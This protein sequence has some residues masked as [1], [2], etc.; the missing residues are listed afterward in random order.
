MM[1]TVVSLLAHGLFYVSEDFADFYNRTVAAFFRGLLSVVT[2]IFPFSL[3]EL[4]IILLLP[5]L[6]FLMVMAYRLQTAEAVRRFTWLVAVVPLLMYNLFVVTFAAGYRTTPLAQR[7]QKESSVQSQTTQLEALYDTA[8]WL[9]EELQALEPSVRVDAY[10]ESVSPLGFQETVHALR[11]SYEK[12]AEEG[13]CAT[14]PGLAKPVFLS[15][16]MSYTHILGVYTF[17]TGEANVNV[18]FTDSVTAFTAAH[19][20]AHQRGF[21][22]EDEANFMAFLACTQSDEP[23][24]R[25]AGY[26]ELLSYVISDL[27]AADAAHYEDV[28]ERIP[29]VVKG[30]WRRYDRLFAPYRDSV[31]GNVSGAVND[32]FLKLQGTEGRISYNRVVALAVSYRQAQVQEGHAHK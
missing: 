23:Y 31:A 20:M 9:T 13:F 8:L 17:F 15:S 12:L 29:T 6:V 11:A 21:S 5:V 14:S 26:A 27:Y 1:V 4:L 30:D 25:Y 18:Q 10:G 16:L 3:A 19:E 32:T 24:L 7:W 28:C 2:W 22:R